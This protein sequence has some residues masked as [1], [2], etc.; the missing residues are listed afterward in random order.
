MHQ[1]RSKNIPNTSQR[2]LR[3]IPQVSETIQDISATS[4]MRQR[5]TQPG[6]VKESTYLVK[7]STV[8]AVVVPPEVGL[9]VGDDG[10]EVVALQHIGT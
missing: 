8:D 4:Q 5:F 1:K 2:R 7:L 9:G 10:L 3:C 6:K